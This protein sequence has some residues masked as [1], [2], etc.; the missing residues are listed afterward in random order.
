AGSAEPSYSG[1]FGSHAMDIACQHSNDAA[2]QPESNN[3]PGAFASCPPWP[4]VASQA[5]TELNSEAT[6]EVPDT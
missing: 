4:S 6:E 2:V 5:E 3:Q 1:H